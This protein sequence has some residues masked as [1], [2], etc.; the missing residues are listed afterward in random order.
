MALT[1]KAVDS[2]AEPA[3]ESER[4]FWNWFKGEEKALYNSLKSQ[5]N[6]EEMLQKIIDKLHQFN[7]GIFC[8]VGMYD[9]QTAELVLTPDG[10]IKNLAFAEDMVNAAPSLENWRITALKPAMGFENLEIEM[11]G[12][13]FNSDKLKF[14]TLPNEAKPDDIELY[15]VHEDFHPDNL[16]D[17]GNGTLLYLDNAIGEYNMMTQID[18]IQFDEPPEDAEL[19]PID[20]LN[21]YLL[22]REK[23]FVEKYEAVRYNTENDEYASFEAEDEEGMPIIA[24]MNQELLSWD[25]KASHPWILLIEIKYAETDNGM[26]DELTYQQMNELEEGLMQILKDSKGYLNIGRQTYRNVRTI[27]IACKDF[28]EAS[29]VTKQHLKS[30]EDRLE[31]SYSI[32]KDKYWSVV[33]RF[34]D[35]V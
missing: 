14:F 29:R 33:E 12:F 16:N 31:A 19:I 34:M 15:I 11:N 6:V 17:I 23:E 7:D 18:S 10:N 24:V 28:R 2:P 13:T 25:A 22:W 26:P 4:D 5:D 21:E 20:K 9:D 1:K 32:F 27:F 30:F 3:M 8:L 35:A